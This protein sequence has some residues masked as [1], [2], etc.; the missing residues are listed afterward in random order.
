MERL[1]DIFD[2]VHQV[3]SHEGPFEGDCFAVGVEDSFAEVDDLVGVY[4]DLEFVHA[5]EG[6]V[7]V[8]GA[9]SASSYM[10]VK[11]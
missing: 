8:V 11:W 2:H 3:S 7:W 1:V 10:L 4:V 9:A 5:L 6:V